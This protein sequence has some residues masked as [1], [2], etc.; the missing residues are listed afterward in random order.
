MRLVSKKTVRKWAQQLSKK[1][2]V[3]DGGTFAEIGDTVTYKVLPE[4]LTYN[5]NA[6]TGEFQFLAPAVWADGTIR[7]VTSYTPGSTATVTLGSFFQASRVFIKV[8]FG[9]NLAIST[10]TSFSPPPTEETFVYYATRLIVTTAEIEIATQ[11]EID[12]NPDFYNL[13]A[14][15]DTEGGSAEDG[16]IRRELFHIHKED[17]TD[18][19]EDW[20][21]DPIDYA[22]LLIFNSDNGAMTIAR[23]KIEPQATRTLV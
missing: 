1:G 21:I 19:G 2:L 4:G 17:Y 10:I 8:P 7:T 22:N 15:I 9:V 18:A 3:F 6:Q 11:T 13:P 23:N 5:L 20:I 16:W 14:A 12:A